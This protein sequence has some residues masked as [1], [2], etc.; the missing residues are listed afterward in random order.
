VLSLIDPTTVVETAKLL[1]EAAA[2]EALPR[3]E[4]HTSEQEKS[5]EVELA[6]ECRRSYTPSYLNEVSIFF[7][8]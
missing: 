1:L 3:P 7:G 4:G 8:T 2:C 6:K 5:N